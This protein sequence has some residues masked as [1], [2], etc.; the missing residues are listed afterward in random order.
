[1]T[2][3]QEAPK[4]ANLICSACGQGFDFGYKLDKHQEETGHLGQ[5][6]LFKD[7]NERRKNVP[8]RRTAC[9]RFQI[10]AGSGKLNTIPNPEDIFPNR[11]PNHL[12]TAYVDL[13]NAFD[14]YMVN[15]AEEAAKRDKITCSAHS[16]NLSDGRRRHYGETAI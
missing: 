3:T 11:C 9:G 7:A 6:N 16:T 1:M 13:R 4:D 2:E 14:E 8:D 15:L 10:H 12:K 5:T